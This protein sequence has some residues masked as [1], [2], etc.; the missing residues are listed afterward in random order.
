MKLENLLFNQD[1]LEVKF[2]VWLNILKL[3]IRYVLSFKVLVQLLNSV[4][5]RMQVCVLW[6]SLLRKSRA[7]FWSTTKLDPLLWIKEY[8][9]NKKLI[10]Q[11]YTTD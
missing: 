1:T 8:I 6:V 9:K 7:H 10:L 3:F 5:E 2:Q 11:T 4:G